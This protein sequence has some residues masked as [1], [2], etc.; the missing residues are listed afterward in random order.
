MKGQFDRSLATYK[1][2]Y[3]FHNFT[4]GGGDADELDFDDEDQVKERMNHAKQAGRDL[5]TL[6]AKKVQLWQERGWYAL[7]DGRSVLVPVCQLICLLIH[8]LRYG[9]SPKVV[10]EKIRN[11]ATALSDPP[12]GNDSD[13]N[14]SD[15]EAELKTVEKA[16]TRTPKTSST[17]VAGRASNSATVSEP[18]HTP[19]SRFRAQSQDAMSGVSEYFRSKA[20]LERKRIETVEARLEHDKAK[21]KISLARQLLEQKDS[22]LDWAVRE[23]ANALLLKHLQG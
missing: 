9:K 14:S 6:N 4:G 22:D 20:E 3:E 17:K 16:N 18:K 12:E 15:S 1:Q 21:D 11:S 2:L 7:F 23:A 5:G 10:R 13:S 8:L 19:A